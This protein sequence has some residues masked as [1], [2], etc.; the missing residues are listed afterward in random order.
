MYPAPA[1]ANP[2]CL[3]GGLRFR[4]LPPVAS[5]F[6]GRAF[7]PVICQGC[8]L[9][10]LEP[11]LPLGELLAYYQG[12]DTREDLEQKIRERFRKRVDLVAGAVPPGSAVLDVGCGRGQFPAALRDAGFRAEGVEASPDLVERGRAEFDLEIHQAAFDEWETDR[13]YQAITA[14]HV[15]EHFVDPLAVLRRARG[16]LDPGTGRLFLEVPNHRS[17]GALLAGASWVHYDVPYHQHFF[18][19]ATLEALCRRAGLEVLRVT[20]SPLDSDWWSLKRSLQRRIA[21]SWLGWLRPLVSLKP[22]MVLL[23]WLGALAGRT[24]TFQLVARV[25]PGGGER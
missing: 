25:A 20:R 8:R 24:E 16:L 5:R 18:E 7:V 10:G 2:C 21:G 13:R 15:L 9:V 19:P 23:A 6:D 1:M 4:E 22:V 3:C 12:L 14:W 11:R 17:L